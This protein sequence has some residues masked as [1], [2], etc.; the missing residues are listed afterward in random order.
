[1]GLSDDQVEAVRVAGLLHDVGKI[2]VPEAILTKAGGLTSEEKSI[3][4]NHVRLTREILAKIHFSDDLHDVP[5][6]ASQHHERL[7][8][9]GYPDGLRG[10][11]LLLESRILA[12]ADVFD[13]LTSHRYYREP[14]SEQEALAEIEQGA[15]VLFDEDVIEALKQLVAEGAEDYD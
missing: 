9:S 7:D 14:V 11:E 4:R 5:I 2:G 12:V 8:G 10:E 13:A 15:G 1:M 3:M 6:I